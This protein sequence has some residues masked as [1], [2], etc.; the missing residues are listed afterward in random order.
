MGTDHKRP[1][2]RAVEVVMVPLIRAVARHRWQGVDNLPRS[3][4]VVLAVN[5]I[6][7]IDPLTLGYFVDRAG[8]VPLFMAKAEL[9]EHR[10]LGM[11]FRGTGMIRV[12]RGA[13]G[14]SASVAAAAAAV[15]DGGCVIVYPEATITRDPNL[16]PMLGKTGAARIA[17]ET[18]APVLPVAQ[19]G[20]HRLLPPYGRRPVLWPRVTV[21]ARV[22]APVD[23]SDLP[24][25]GPTVEVLEV[26]TERIVAAITAELE[27]IRGERAPA[28]RFDPRGSGSG[29]PVAGTRGDSGT[30]TRSSGERP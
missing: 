21:R 9:F 3:G 7:K 17:L 15:R 6:S 18:G 10:W 19:W 25:R 14:A 2:F 23:L 16:W 30:D 4:G 8:R 29:H 27:C 5:H 28:T 22:G 13:E 24:A 26:A 20:A 11:I 1:W 12:Q